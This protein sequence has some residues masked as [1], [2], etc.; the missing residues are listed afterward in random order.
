[1]NKPQTI[2]EQIVRLERAERK[3]GSDAK[4]VARIQELKARDAQD[5]LH[6]YLWVTKPDSTLHRQR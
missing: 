1:M 5:Y 6:S 3:F 2:Q 4:R